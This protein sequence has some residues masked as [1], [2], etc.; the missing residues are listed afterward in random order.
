MFPKP[1]IV[2]VNGIRLA[3]HEQGSG[4]PVILLHGFPELAY[5]WRHQ[6]PALAAAGYRAIAP[7]LR[8]YGAS[9]KPNG[10][11]DYTIQELIGDVTGMMDSLGIEKA[12]IIGHDW[13]A[14]LAWQMTLLVPKR[15]SGL[16]NLNIP[17]FPRPPIDPIAY[18]RSELGKD[19][20]IVNF[21]D[22]DL[23]DRTCA[24]DP[25]RVFD[26]MMRRNQITRAE[27]DAL[28]RQM[29]QFSLLAALSRTELSGE[30]I[31]TPEERRVFVDAFTAGGF[32]GPINWYRNWTRNWETTAD[33]EQTVR[34]PTLFI[35]ADNEVIVSVQQIE[36]MKPHVENLKVHML[37]NCGHWSQQEHPDEVNAL[38][39]DW[40][41]HQ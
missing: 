12:V 5:S 2:D 25:G 10:V 32:T 24:A 9:G 34:V 8:G 37:E 6:L 23:A 38:I 39:L 28:P 7:D 4:P 36:A 14:L 1:R 21:Q 17:F 11:A 35:G 29:R 13:G 41:S 40:L 18:M 31:L 22:S 15:M 26:V 27:F 20:Y 3:V 16:I 19:Y 30:P 33:V